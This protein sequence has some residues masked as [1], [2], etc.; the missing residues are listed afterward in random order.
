VA[1]IRDAAAAAAALR[2][3]AADLF[4]ERARYAAGFFVGLHTHEGDESFEL[5]EGRMRFAVG[6]EWRTGA[7]GDIVF[8]PAGVE[9]GF[10][11]ETD[12]VIDIFSQQDMGLYV[13]VVEPDG[14]R[15]TEEVFMQGFPSTHAAPAGQGWTPRAHIRALYATTRELL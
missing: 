9:H 14:S 13:I 5:R 4:R 2:D 6:D 3:K 11:C 15:R 10:V 12:V 7:L 1:T 8:V